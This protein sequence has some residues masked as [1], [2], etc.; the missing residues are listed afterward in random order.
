MLCHTRFHAS[1]VIFG[2]KRPLRGVADSA[3]CAFAQRDEFVARNVAEKLSAA[4][5]HIVAVE[6]L[7]E[8]F[9]LH[10]SHIALA[11]TEHGKHNHECQ[12]NRDEH[13]AQ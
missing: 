4:G 9:F 3:L 1:D 13:G 11:E 10:R 12:C 2:M 8:A 6:L 7:V 5:A